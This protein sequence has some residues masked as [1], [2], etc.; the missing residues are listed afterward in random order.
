MTLSGETELIEGDGTDADVDDGA[1]LITVGS[2]SHARERTKELEIA[3][4]QRRTLGM[5]PSLPVINARAREVQPGATPQGEYFAGKI[6]RS[7][8]ETFKIP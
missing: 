3:S 4:L 6:A 2:A 1:L 5:S 7:L 8:R